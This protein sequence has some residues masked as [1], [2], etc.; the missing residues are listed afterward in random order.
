MSLTSA[1]GTTNANVYA[2]W[3]RMWGGMGQTNGPWRYTLSQI[4]QAPE[5]TAAV[6]HNDA[7]GTSQ[8]RCVSVRISCGLI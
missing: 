8:D 2:M 1:R 6:E 5:V 7:W 3:C 4:Y